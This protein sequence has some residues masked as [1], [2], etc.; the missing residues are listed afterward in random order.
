MGEASKQNR[1]SGGN[2]RRALNS[3]AAGR[4]YGAHGGFRKLKAFHTESI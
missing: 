1:Q 3:A 4:V 2:D